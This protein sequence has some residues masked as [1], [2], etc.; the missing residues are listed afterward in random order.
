MKQLTVKLPQTKE[1]KP[2]LT[3]G[4]PAYIECFYTDGN[5]NKIKLSPAGIV[6]IKK[7][8]HKRLGVSNYITYIEVIDHGT[9]YSCSAC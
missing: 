5:Y 6:K 2:F 3:W 7:N 1:K 9:H 8:T 4:N